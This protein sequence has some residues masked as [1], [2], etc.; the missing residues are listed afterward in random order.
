MFNKNLKYYRLKKNMTKAALATACGVSP[1]TISN[2]ESGKRKPDMDMINQLAEVLGIHVVDF[3][4]SRNDTLSIE[5]GEFRKKSILTKSEQ[6]YVHE[7]VEEYFSR[8]FSAVNMFGGDPLPEAPEC[9]CLSISGNYE[10]DAA[11]LREYFDL[12]KSGPIEDLVA[13]LENKGFL[14]L[15]LDIK[16]DAFSGIN[17]FVNGYPYIAIREDMN[18]M[19]KRT[20][21]VHELAHILFSWEGSVVNEEKHA[22]AIAGA[23][24]ITREDLYRKLGQKRSSMTR[25]M[26]LVCREYGIST[27][28]LATR[29]VQVGIMSE[30]AA[31][32]F[33]IKAN[34]AGWRSGEPEWEIKSES[35]TLFKSLVYRAVSEEDLGM[36]RAAELLREPYSEIEKYCADVVGV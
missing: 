14:V 9:N 19:R 15:F 20:T 21:L 11:S 27:Y 2:Y 34:K 29:A 16:N 17:G 13:L 12:P 24:L 3:L 7:A 31:R 6:E 26:T 18:V 4:A 35:P 25:D 32:T 30:G 1:M 23:F 10:T 28:L 33:F 8:F 5:H 22:T 36:Q